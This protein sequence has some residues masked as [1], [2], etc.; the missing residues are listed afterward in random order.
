MSVKENCRR[1][2]RSCLPLLAVAKVNEE[3]HVISCCT[4]ITHA[5]CQKRL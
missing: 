3:L 2:T 4:L 5:C 1:D